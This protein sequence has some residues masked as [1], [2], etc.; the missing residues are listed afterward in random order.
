MTRAKK[1]FVV[2]DRYEQFIARQVE[3]GRFNNASEV[4][5]AGLR[6]LEDYETRLGALRQEIAKGDSDIEAGRV[7][8]YAGADD[9]FQDIIKDPGR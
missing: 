7:T 5:R 1:S 3:E 4:I 6:M 8:P 9:L 2:G